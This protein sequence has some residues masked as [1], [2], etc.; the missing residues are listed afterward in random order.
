MVLC[1]C[2]FDVFA[3]VV[4]MYLAASELKFIPMLK[5]VSCLFDNEK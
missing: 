3:C 4:Y 2:L 5:Y 1:I